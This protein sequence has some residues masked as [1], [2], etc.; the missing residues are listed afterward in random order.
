MPILFNLLL[1]VLIAPLAAYDTLRFQKSA[2]RTAPGG[3]SL[4][5]EVQL[6][7]PDPRTIADKTLR[8]LLQHFVAPYERA[9]HERNLTAEITENND[10]A[11]AHGEWYDATEITPFSRTAYSVTFQSAQ[12][13][14]NGGAHGYD[15]RTYTNLDPATAAPITM[16]NLIAPDR[17]D[18]FEKIA[19][20]YYR[21]YFSIAPST[22]LVETGWFKNRFILPQ[23]FAITPDGLLMHYDSYEIKPYALGQTKYRIP[24]HALRSVIAPHSPFA[25]LCSG[26]RPLHAVLSD[27]RLSLTLDA[28]RVAA[29]EA[30]ISLAARSLRPIDKAWISLSFPQLTAHDISLR[31]L[32]RQG[33]FHLHRYPA[34][35]RISRR[36]H[37]PIQARYLLIEAEQAPFRKDATFRF[38]IRLHP[39]QKLHELIIDLRA[40]YAAK[41]RKTDLPD[42]NGAVGQQGYRNERYFLGL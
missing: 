28:L 18:R 19:E 39:P 2:M 5:L 24:W 29:N 41:G 16:H 27:D 4:K 20:R 34:A 15:T 25:A 9:Y 42:F 36:D 26:D 22:P 3:D 31:T 12:R 37:T 1:V 35:S 23:T 7:Y 6:S 32:Q 10:T 33:R 13:G 14:Y 11:F 8:R 21:R 38:T 40:V 30:V 17:F